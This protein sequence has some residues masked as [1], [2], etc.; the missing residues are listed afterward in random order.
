MF[1]R[2]LLAP[3]SL[4]WWIV[5]TF[6]NIFYNIKV[7]PVKK[8]KKPIIV[9]GNLA[10]GGTGKTPHTLYVLDLLRNNFRVASLSRGYGRKTSGFIVANYD[11]NA[12][13]IGDEPMIFFNRFKNRIVVSVG[14]SRVDAIDRLL[15]RFRLDAIVLDDAFQHRALQA[16]FYILLTDYNNRYS[17]DYLMPMGSLRES[18]RG[19]NRANVIIVTK[20]PENLSE[21]EKAE[22]KQE[23]KI[24]KNQYL[25]FSTIKYDEE[26]KHIDF[27]ISVSEMRNYNVLLITGIAKSEGLE[28][29]IKENSQTVRHL[30]Y[31]DHYDFRRSDIE[32]VAGAFESMAEP[33]MIVTTEK[34]YMK[35]RH[36]HRIV[37]N[38]YYLPISVE[39]DQPEKFNHIILSYVHKV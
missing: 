27:D 19:A 37:R 33:K 5:T 32:D 24:K 1:W 16:G 18:R 35:L 20:C 14:E 15:K 13:Q 28:K 12:R 39:I 11:S 29:Y 3:V 17:K 38:L 23:L 10:V 21:E 2:K 22:I 25:F 9:V 34:D 4:I 7:F 8:F 31:P 26:L 30:K 36:E 6:R